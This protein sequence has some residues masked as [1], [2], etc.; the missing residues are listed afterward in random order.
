MESTNKKYTTTLYPQKRKMFRVSLTLNIRHLNIQ[1]YTQEKEPAIW[2]HLAEGSPEKLI[3]SMGGSR[4]QPIMIQGCLTFTTLKQKAISHY[5]GRG[6]SPE[7]FQ[8]FDYTSHNA[9]RWGNGHLKLRDRL[10]YIESIFNTFFTGSATKL[11]ALKHQ[12]NLGNWIKI[13]FCEFNFLDNSL[14]NYFLL[15]LKKL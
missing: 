14:I 6:T 7:D 11:L 3:T 12:A 13:D 15:I 8:L 2:G 1:H 4:G 5:T 10:D 9:K